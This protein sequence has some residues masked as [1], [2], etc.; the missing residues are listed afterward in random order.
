M[1]PGGKVSGLIVLWTFLLSLSATGR[2]LAHGDHG[3]AAPLEGG[4][5]LVTLDGFQA[6]LLTSPRPPRAGEENKIVVKI[7]RHGSLDPVRNAKVWIGVSPAQLDPDSFQP[8]TSVAVRGSGTSGPV[9]SQA[10]EEVWAGN[11]TVVR[12]FSRQG[13]YLVRVAL[14]ELEE[15]KFDPPATL[16]FYLNVGRSAGPTPGLIFGLLTAAVIGG[17][18]IYWGLLRSRAHGPI[19]LLDIRWVDRLVRWKGFLPGLQIPVLVLTFVIMLLGFF[20]IQDGAKNLATKVTWIIWWPGIIFTFIL[21]GRFWC[22]PCPFGTINE[23]AARLAKPRAM[24]PRRLR[25][26]WLATLFFVLLTWADEQLGII[27]SPMMT[28]WLIV[29]LGL[30]AVGTGL[31]FQRRSFCLPRPRIS[32][33]T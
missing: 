2:V 23:W 27:R 1:T 28:A 16:E 17:G 26:L 22:V 24:F 33:D 5:S 13:T 32:L 6:E 21:V 10:T 4:I 19:N 8:G 9:L 18:G 30:A 3:D 7:L 11:Y 12:R 25:G 15:R 14:S 20:D 29:F 31:L